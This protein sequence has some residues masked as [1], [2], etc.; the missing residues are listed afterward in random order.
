MSSKFLPK[1]FIKS[2][3]TNSLL[4]PRNPIRNVSAEI[5]LSDSK[6]MI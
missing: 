1:I 5:I 3:E 6:S 2:K 4:I